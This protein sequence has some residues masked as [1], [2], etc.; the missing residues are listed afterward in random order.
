MWC[1]EGVT[2]DHSKKNL[3]CIPMGNHDYNAM[4]DDAKHEYDSLLTMH[5]TDEKSFMNRHLLI[6]PPNYILYWLCA[7]YRGKSRNRI[8]DEFFSLQERY[9]VLEVSRSKH[10]F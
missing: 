10:F 4:F 6:S 2:C 5:V 3:N 1:V 9:T 8:L 7:Q